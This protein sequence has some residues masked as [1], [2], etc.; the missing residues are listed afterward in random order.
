MYGEHIFAAKSQGNK[1]KV[2]AKGHFWR[3]RS[4][5]RVQK[6]SL[7][8]VGASPHITHALPVQNSVRFL[9][10]RRGQLPRGS[11]TDN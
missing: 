7:T 2:E 1:A 3:R 6:W 5:I 8:G 4:H 11:Q 9:T 10:N